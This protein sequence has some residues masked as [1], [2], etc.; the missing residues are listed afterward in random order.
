MSACHRTLRRSTAAAG[1]LCVAA[2]LA[3]CT[4]KDAVSSDP[5][6]FRYVSATAPGKTYPIAERKL[7]GQFSEKLLDASTTYSLKQDLGKVV[8]LNFWATW[9]PPCVVETPQFDLVYRDY[10]SKGVDFVGI[11]TKDERSS[12]RSFVKE[13]SITYPIV[14]DQQGETAIRLGKIPSAALP[15]TVIIDKHGK[16]AVVYQRSMSPKDLTPLLDSLLAEA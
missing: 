14:F 6:V 1:A 4:G 7:A 15:F 8:V 2:I 3:A 16:V 13:N 10:K 12:A 5:N 9:C 11:D